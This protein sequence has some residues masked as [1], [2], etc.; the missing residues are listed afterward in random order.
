[1]CP[2]VI[3]TDTGNIV[4]VKDYGSIDDY[5]RTA[6]HQSVLAGHSVAVVDTPMNLQT[7]RKAILPGTVSL[8]YKLGKTV[9]RARSKLRDP[10]Q[11]VVD[12]LKGWKFFQG[13]VSSFKWKNEGGFL[14]AELR[15]DGT[16]EYKGQQLK[17]WIMNEH[18][19]VWRNRKPAVMPPDLMSL[20]KN[21]GEAVTNGQVKVG[22]RLSAIAARAPELWRTAKG[23]ELFGPRHFGFDFDYVPVEKLL[24]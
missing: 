4:I 7:A 23:L 14:K 20:V 3:V 16:G 10:V 9:V 17:S 8:C 22:M 12:T 13:K 19:M 21:N 11:A 15:L 5:E 2:S 18:I 1:M 6:R 24:G